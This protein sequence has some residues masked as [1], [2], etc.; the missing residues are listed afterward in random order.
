V[1]GYQ[2]VGV[3]GSYQ[4]IVHV[5]PADVDPTPQARTLPEQP[6]D[7]AAQSGDETQAGAN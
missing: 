5:E 2:N 7:D 3:K 6:Q 4:V 1:N